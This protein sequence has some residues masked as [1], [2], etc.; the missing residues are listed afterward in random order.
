MTANVFRSMLDQHTHTH[1]TPFTG[2]K[3][4]QESDNRYSKTFL[5]RVWMCR[6]VPGGPV[7][8]ISPSSA[9]SAGS[10]PGERTQI[11]HAS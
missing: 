11:P 10:I 5:L 4:E 2:R 7:V 8:E 6:D 3:G 9:G 1:H